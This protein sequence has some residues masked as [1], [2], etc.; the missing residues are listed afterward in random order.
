MLDGLSDALVHFAAKLKDTVFG[1]PRAAMRDTCIHHVRTR[2]S[3]E[4][5][6]A[7]EAFILECCE[8]ILRSVMHFDLLNA[9]RRSAS[10]T[11]PPGFIPGRPR[12]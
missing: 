6:L 8:E 3:M 4:L 7:P 1:F 5:Q 12:K 11:L 2:S 10:Y 9:V